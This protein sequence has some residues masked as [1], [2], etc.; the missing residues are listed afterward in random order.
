MPWFNLAEI[1]DD[2]LQAMYRY[3]RA[4]GPAGSPAPA[5]V[6]PGTTVTTPFIVFV[7]QDPPTAP[8][9]TSRWHAEATQAP[10]G[11]LDQFEGP[12]HAQPEAATAGFFDAHAGRAVVEPALEQDQPRLEVVDDVGQPEAQIK[13]AARGS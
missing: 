12:Q 4:A 13:G 9:S 11:D 2:D 5:R 1:P 6:A 10:A 8:P 3:L 7:S